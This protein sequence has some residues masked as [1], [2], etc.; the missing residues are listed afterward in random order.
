MSFGLEI[1]IKNIKLKN[2]TR[3][4]QKG[5][6]ARIPFPP[7]PFGEIRVISPNNLRGRLLTRFSNIEGVTPTL[8]TILRA[9]QAIADFSVPVIKV[10]SF[11]EL[12][13]NTEK[14][15]VVAT[16]LADMRTKT[17]KLS[18]IK[19]LDL[20]KIWRRIYGF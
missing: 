13:V 20:G 6:I 15:L 9:L 7:F 4:E 2:T 10:G 19:K 1:E 12:K 3:V 8:D 11:Y 17:F 5:D 16:G 14:G 18:D